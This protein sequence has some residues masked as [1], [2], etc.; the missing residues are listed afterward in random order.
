MNWSTK[1]SKDYSSK[2]IKRFSNGLVSLKGKWS[3][4]NELNSLGFLLPTIFYNIKKV[5][6]HMHIH[7]SSIII[8][9]FQ[10]MK[11]FRTH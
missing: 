6:I 4:G 7:N 11:N 9:K 2:V 5:Y 3:W 8:S 10:K 1:G